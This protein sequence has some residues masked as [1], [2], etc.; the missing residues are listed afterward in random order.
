MNNILRQQYEDTLREN[1]RLRAALT[2]IAAARWTDSHGRNP[3]AARE[4]EIARKALGIV[5]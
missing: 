4:A 3:I 5:D 2:E 1:E